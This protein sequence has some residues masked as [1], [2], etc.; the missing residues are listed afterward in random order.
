MTIVFNLTN[1]ARGQ[2]IS[3][4]YLGGYYFSAFVYNFLLMDNLTIKL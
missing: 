1:Q 2:K 3:I 4:F